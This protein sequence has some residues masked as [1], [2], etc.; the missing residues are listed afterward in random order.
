MDSLL[1]TLAFAIGY[2]HIIMGA[3]MAIGAVV[4]VVKEVWFPDK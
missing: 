3:G 4:Y 1:D 2:W